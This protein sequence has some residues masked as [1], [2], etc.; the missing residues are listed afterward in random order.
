M[1]CILNIIFISF[2]TS[3]YLSVAQNITIKGRVI[4]NKYNNPLAYVYVVKKQTNT[5]TITESDGYF[6]INANKNDTLLISCYGFKLQRVPCAN[7]DSNNVYLVKMLPLQYDL[8]TVNIFTQY[9]LREAAE[10]IGKK[11]EP[12]INK[13]EMARSSAFEHPITYFYLKYN[14]LEKSKREAEMLING[15]N[16]MAVLRGLFKVY[17][18]ENYQK[19]DPKQLDDFINYCNLSDFFIK[20]STEYE[21]AIHILRKFDSYT[22]NND[23]VRPQY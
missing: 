7:I 10:I 9:N 20:T 15:D 11:N 8:N 17:L 4:D 13:L 1:K 18:F 2:F 12:N 23:Y 5:G 19:L 22:N 14:K 21:L 6:T 3:P 16:R